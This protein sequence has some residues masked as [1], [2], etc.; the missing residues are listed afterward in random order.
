MPLR[1]GL[2]RGGIRPTMTPTR[3]WKINHAATNASAIAGM[4][5]TTG[6]H[7]GGRGHD[8]QKN[9]HFP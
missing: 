5:T 7:E 3:T 2:L 6:Q 9:P 4:K 1:L 8:A